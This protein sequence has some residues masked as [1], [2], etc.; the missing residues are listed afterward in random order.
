ML[1]KDNTSLYFIVLYDCIL[2]ICS[3]KVMM[4]MMIALIPLLL[5]F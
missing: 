1:F 4:L 2:S 3:I 5:K